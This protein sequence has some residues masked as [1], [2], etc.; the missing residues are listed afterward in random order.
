MSCAIKRFDPHPE[1]LEPR[2]EATEFVYDTGLMSQF[3]VKP[4]KQYGIDGQDL[5]YVYIGHLPDQCGLA[6]RPFIFGKKWVLP[7]YDFA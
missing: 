4:P 3:E 6:L 5:D 1:N 2:L 7:K